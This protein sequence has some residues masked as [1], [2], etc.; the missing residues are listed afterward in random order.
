M[1]ERMTRLRAIRLKYGISLI[2]MER[3]SRVS[4]QYLSALELGNVSRTANTEE[5][6]SC[7]IDEIIRSR[8]SSLLGLEQM[9]RQY[10]GHLLETV[11]VEK[12]E[13]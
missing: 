3:H 9:I 11:E 2:E 12:G 4:N 13:L 7:A 1:M 6:L 8:K 10:R 5:V